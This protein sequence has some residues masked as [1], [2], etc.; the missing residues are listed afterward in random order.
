LQHAE[1]AAVALVW[2]QSPCCQS[3]LNQLT[4]RG[5]TRRS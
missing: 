4:S 3:P 5:V 2:K 1:S